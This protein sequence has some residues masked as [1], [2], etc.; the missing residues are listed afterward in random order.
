MNV[1]ASPPGS[2]SPP[3]QRAAGTPCVSPVL[4]LLLLETIR[5]YDR[6]EE[7]L[8]EEDITLSM[9]RRLGLSEVVRVQIGR[10]SEEVRLKRPQIASQVEDLFR[11]VIRRPDA[12]EVFVEAGQRVAN[13]YWEE[14]A[15]SVKR[16]VVVL[17][18]ALAVLWAQRAAKRM[19]AEL[20]GPTR[21]QITR[22]PL[23]LRIEQSMS[24]VADPG[25]AACAF[26]AG[27]FGRILTLYT[28]RQ[29]RVVHS[30]CA[31]RSQSDP[32]VWTAEFA[33]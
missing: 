14:R 18:H 32:C 33:A 15:G 26:Y 2:S 12:D 19:L 22:K 11:L 7:V 13:R 24:A 30:T 8:E 9:P 20:V 28:S 17:P 31:A 16:T 27:A 5:D 23:T 29:C 1:S 4:P 6:P 25:G 10:F 3:A 21:F